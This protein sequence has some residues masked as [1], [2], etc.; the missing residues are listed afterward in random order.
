MLANSLIMYIDNSADMFNLLISE[1]YLFYLRIFDDLCEYNMYIFIKYKHEYNNLIHTMLN[2]AMETATNIITIAMFSANPR[3]P[4]HP[5]QALPDP[6]PQS[7]LLHRFFAIVEQSIDRVSKS[8][9]KASTHISSPIPTIHRSIP[10]STMN[11]SQSIPGANTREFLTS[12]YNEAY[13]K[14]KSMSYKNQCYFLSLITLLSVLAAAACFEF[15]VLVAEYSLNPKTENEKKNQRPTVNIESWASDIL[16]PEITVFTLTGAQY[17]TTAVDEE[18]PT[19]PAPRTLPKSQPD[20]RGYS[21]PKQKILRR[22]RKYS[23]RSSASEIEK[24]DVRAEKKKRDYSAKVIDE[25]GIHLLDPQKKKCMCCYMKAFLNPDEAHKLLQDVQ[26]CMED[27]LADIKDIN[28]PLE[29][30]FDEEAQNSPLLS[31][32]INFLRKKIETANA[33]IFGCS[34]TVS[35]VIIRRLRSLK[36]HIP[37]ESPSGTH[38]CGNNPTITILSLGASRS[39]CLKKKN[40]P[41]HKTVLQAGSLCSLTGNSTFE[42]TYSVL[43]GHQETAEEEQILLFFIGT[44]SGCTEYES[45]HGPVSSV[46]APTEPPSE[47]EV[48]SAGEIEEFSVFNTLPAAESEAG[49]ADEIMS[50]ILNMSRFVPE[51]EV[52]ST[53]TLFT[54][55]CDGDNSSQDLSPDPA[56]HDKTV[57]PASVVYHCSTDDANIDNLSSE[58]NLSQPKELKLNIARPE[59][60]SS[61]Q[62]EIF[63]EKSPVI[64]ES[65]TNLPADQSSD[66]VLS[67]IQD[68]LIELKTGMQSLSSEMF[69]LRS[70]LDDMKAQ[71]GKNH[72]N[73]DVQKMTDLWQ[74][75]ITEISKVGK[76]V[77]NNFRDIEVSQV[78]IAELHD[79]LEKF[80][81]DLNNYYNSAFFKEDSDLIKQIHRVITS[82]MLPLNVQA[83]YQ[84]LLPPLASPLTTGAHQPPVSI[85]LPPTLPL[86]R[87]TSSAPLPPPPP[88]PQQPTMRHPSFLLL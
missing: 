60:A 80:K 32:C 14:Q 8:S 21:T 42:Y 71:V 7:P 51:D 6:L 2:G 84:P 77:D 56:L 9:R 25:D 35:K 69:H 70:D 13:N 54:Q 83:P 24:N 15:F 59:G 30:D 85:V 4:R 65:D 63:T 26:R 87:P 73:N 75:G 40:R 78:K 29:L 22:I 76:L 18:E 17:L 39:L 62:E 34:T 36:D 38:G 20:P 61:H 33:Q 50:D 11:G 3:T 58:A 79:H 57:I 53:N 88:P 10:N 66:P 46:S 64:P 43:K 31:E 45:D 55:P 67:Q 5:P 82:P 27:P 74:T 86:P 48:S 23:E 72:Q 16:N 28:A 37:Y 19:S 44:P 52:N 68:T 1:M 47:S 41:T 81:T 12:R 49:P